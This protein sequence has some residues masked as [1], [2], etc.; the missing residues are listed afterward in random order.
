MLIRSKSRVDEKYYID[1]CGV[2][3]WEDDDSLFSLGDL[4]DEGIIDSSEREATLQRRKYEW[5]IWMR[6][7]YSVL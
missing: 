4:L 2:Y 1:R 3:R 5:G 7:K 6:V